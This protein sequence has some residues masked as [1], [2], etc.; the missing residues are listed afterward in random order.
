MIGPFCN[1][2]WG[3]W[4]AG[5]GW[6][7]PLAFLSLAGLAVLRL[8]QSSPPANGDRAMGILAERYARGD[9]A[10]DTYE[11]MRRDLS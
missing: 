7:V 11:A 4:G 9:I 1:W 6:L 2:G 10:R 8:S 5:L 3:W